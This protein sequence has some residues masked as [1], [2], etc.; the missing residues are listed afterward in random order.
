MENKIENKIE[1][2]DYIRT[3]KGEIGRVFRIYLAEEDRKKYP[4]N[5]FKNYWRDKYIVDTRKGNCT[6][7]AIKKHSKEIKDLIEIGDYVNEIKVKEITKDYIEGSDGSCVV[8]F[9][10]I[11]S[12]VTKEQFTSI[13]YKLE[14]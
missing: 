13:E 7:Q 4:N 8:N 10:E 1:V 11:K 14:E 12:I 5:R 2:G 3:H 9:K 6:R